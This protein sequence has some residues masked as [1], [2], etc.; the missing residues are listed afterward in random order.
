MTNTGLSNSKEATHDIHFVWD[1]SPSQVPGQEMERWGLAVD[2]WGGFSAQGKT[3][4]AFYEDTLDAQGYQDIVGELAAAG[5]A[6]VV[7][8]RKARVGTPAR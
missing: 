7:W 4:L 6:R 2:A 3:E 1:N 8:R 5:R